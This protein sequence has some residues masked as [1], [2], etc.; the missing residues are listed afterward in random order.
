MRERF[1]QRRVVDASAC[2]GPARF[3]EA[4]AATLRDEIAQHV[5]GPRIE[6]DHVLRARARDKREVRDAAEVEEGDRRAVGE[7]HV[8]AEGHERR[9]LASRGDVGAAEVG[10]RRDARAK[11]DPRRVTELKRRVT[12]GQV[13]DRLSVHCDDVRPSVQRRDERAGRVRVRVA[14]GGVQ[15]REIRRRRRVVR[16]RAGARGPPR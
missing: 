8:V 3:V 6:R 11:G 4:F 7:E 12:I 13:G 15:D 10:D 16:G 2:G 5:R 9:A 14:E 1:V